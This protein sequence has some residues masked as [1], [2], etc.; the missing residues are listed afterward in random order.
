MSFKARTTA[1][2]LVVVA[3][4]YGWYFA[5]LLLEAAS[6]PV[7]EIDYQ[8]LLFV[9]VV[10]LVVL[11]TIGVAVLAALARR[12]ANED[13]DERDKL[14]EM[15]GAQVGRDVLTVAVL[16]AMGVAVVGGAQFWIANI[17]LAGLV[18]GELAKGTVMLVR[19]RRGV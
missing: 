2:M 15:R 1:V 8:G 5:Q 13:E 12:E 9:M 16:V 3:I 17:L 11:F 7:D 14:I 6:T 4:V 19:Y 18:L 10:I